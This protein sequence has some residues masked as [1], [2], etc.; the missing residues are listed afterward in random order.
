[1]DASLELS[2]CSGQFL[3]HCPVRVSPVGTRWVCC[4]QHG[5]R[6]QYYWT[7][8]NP[9]S[10]KKFRSSFRYYLD[11]ILI[12][13]LYGCG[14]FSHSIPHQINIILLNMHWHMHNGVSKTGV[15]RICIFKCWTQ[16]LQA[17]TILRNF[18]EY[19]ELCFF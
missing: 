15:F 13:L 1:M 10:Y 2:K 5:R 7:K 16:A 8:S 4:K 17:M 12:I 18:A 6:N 3:S 19:K 11:N 9:H 14:F